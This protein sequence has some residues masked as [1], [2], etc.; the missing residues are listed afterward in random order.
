MEQNEKPKSL[1]MRRLLHCL[2]C[3]L[4][5]VEFFLQGIAAIWGFFH[6]SWIGVLLGQGE[7]TIDG[8]YIRLG[9]ER[10]ANRQRDSVN[11]R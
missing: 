7:I 5:L 10:R 2:W 1:C 3:F 4:A 8:R 9:E 6:T 11:G